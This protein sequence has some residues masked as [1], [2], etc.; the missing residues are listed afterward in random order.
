MTR[1][2]LSVFVTS[3]DI[4]EIPLI[5]TMPPD[6]RASIALVN[7]NFVR[8]YSWVDSDNN[9]ISYYCVT[10]I[11]SYYW[12]P[13]IID[14]NRL[15]TYGPEHG[16][17]FIHVWAFKDGNIPVTEFD[18][19]KVRPSIKLYEIIDN[20]LFA[21][22]DEFIPI[23][24]TPQPFYNG[25]NAFALSRETFELIKSVYDFSI[26]KN[27]IMDVRI[28]TSRDYGDVIFPPGWDNVEASPFSIHTGMFLTGIND[29]VYVNSLCGVYSPY[30]YCDCRLLFN[31]TICK[32]M[33]PAGFYSSFEFGCL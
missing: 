21:L 6:E 8:P 31:E 20:E 25:L 2:R 12:P 13:C 11:K 4:S 28:N 30:N 9:P 18:G 29:D 14:F 5:N 27:I 32:C 26:P 16:P 10:N 24:S 1:F 22:T 33:D 23:V 3:S 7:A 15:D 17:Y 19:L